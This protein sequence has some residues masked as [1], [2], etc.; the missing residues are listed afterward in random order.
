[1][2]PPQILDEG[3]ASDHDAGGPI[4]FEASHWA[5]SG[6]EAPVVSFYPV[7]GVL[8][9]VVNCVREELCNPADQGVGPVGGDLDRLAM[10]GDYRGEELPG[11]LQVSPRGHEYVDDLP[12][13]VNGPVDISPG[14]R[15]L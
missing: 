4:T 11:G 3:M 12:I 1:M 6:L 2:A 8:G 5:K 10:C 15:D 7:V 14:P 9:G 13:S